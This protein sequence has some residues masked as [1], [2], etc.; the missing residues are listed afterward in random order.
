MNP[1]ITN[2]SLDSLLHNTANHKPKP[3]E[4]TEGGPSFQAVL[5]ARVADEPLK[6]SKHAADRIADRGIDISDADWDRIHEKVS[7]AKDKGVTDSL[8]LTEDAALVVSAKNET[9]ITAM[10]RAEAESQIFTNINGT[11]VL[12]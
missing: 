3:K 11:I 8:V 12:E 1:N 6:V 9:V 4:K 5:E 7:E 10:N 2:H